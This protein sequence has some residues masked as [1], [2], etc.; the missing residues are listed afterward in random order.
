MK[1][2]LLSYEV[3]VEH[4]ISLFAIIITPSNEIENGYRMSYSATL[5]ISFLCAKYQLVKIL[6]KELDLEQV[7]RLP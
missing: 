2:Y 1:E 6:G 4:S 7:T 3:F 5:R